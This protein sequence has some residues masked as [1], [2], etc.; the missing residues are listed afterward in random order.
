VDV[1]PGT[2]SGS[3]VKGWETASSKRAHPAVSTVA[4]HSTAIADLGGRNRMPQG[5]GSLGVMRHDAP[6]GCDRGNA[7]WPVDV[8]GKS[9][10]LPGLALT[11]A[12]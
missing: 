4:A 1:C 11:L 5:Y 10:D 8:P 7:D 9:G 12:V 3:V 6:G 2:I